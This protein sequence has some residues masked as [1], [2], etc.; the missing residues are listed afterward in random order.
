VNLFQLRTA[1]WIVVYTVSLLS[2]AASSASAQGNF[3][4][5]EADIEVMKPIHYYLEDK[6]YRE[7]GFAWDFTKET[8][9]LKKGTEPIPEP[10]LN[11]F[12][13]KGKSADTITG[14]WKLVDRTLVFSAIKVDDADLKI[15]VKFELYKTAPTVIRWGSL[16]QFV[17]AA[18][19]LTR[20]P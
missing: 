15:E 20:M 18:E 2:L 4:I 8:F 14:K 6:K 12:L 7:P 9:T 16:P 5:K 10:L 1:S 3:A 13:E 11:Q 17:F 19:P